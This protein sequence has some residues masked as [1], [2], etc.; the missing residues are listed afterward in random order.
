MVSAV[1]AASSATAVSD[2][3]ALTTTMSPTASVG[4]GFTT[5]SRA[6][7]WT[8]QSSPLPSSASTIGAGARVQRMLSCASASRRAMA[9]TC[10]GVFPWQNT[11]SGTP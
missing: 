3:P 4:L 7:A 11:A 9:I 6:S 1:T 10:S 8:R 2:V 5:T